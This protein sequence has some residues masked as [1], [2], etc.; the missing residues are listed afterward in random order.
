MNGKIENAINVTDELIK[1]MSQ[2]GHVKKR[3]QELEK[4]NEGFVMLIQIHNIVRDYGKLAEEVKNNEFNELQSIDQI[5]G[6]LTEHQSWFTRKY[7]FKEMAEQTYNLVAEAKQVLAYLEDEE[8]ESYSDLEIT[9]T[10]KGSKLTY[11]ELVAL[12]DNEAI[13]NYSE[14]ELADNGTILHKDNIM[15]CVQKHKLSQIQDT[16][17]SLKDTAIED[18]DRDDIRWFLSQYDCSTIEQLASDFMFYEDRES[19]DENYVYGIVLQ[20]I[21]NET[22]KNYFDYDKYWDRDAKYAFIELGNGTIAYN[23]L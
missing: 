18:F 8:R 22:V 5:R 6:I 2:E 9:F 16:V 7:T 3:C 11:G 21:D 1:V 23:Q 4:E 15:E 12:E 14:I 17:D 19:F 20:G 13:T 10:Y